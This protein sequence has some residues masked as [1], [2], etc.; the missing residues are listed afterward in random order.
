MAIS[1]HKPSGSNFKPIRGKHRKTMVKLHSSTGNHPNKLKNR[2]LWKKIQVYFFYFGSFWQGG[3]L[4]KPKN[5]EIFISQNPRFFDLFGWFLVELCTFYH[6]LPVFPPDRFK[7]W[8]WW[9]L[10]RYCNKLI[11]EYSWKFTSW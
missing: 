4:L 11:S 1:V 3:P 9:F 10:N 2:G 8:P 6:I 5:S 7:E